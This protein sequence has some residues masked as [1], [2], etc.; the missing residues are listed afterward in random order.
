MAMTLSRSRSDWQYLY[1]KILPIA[2]RVY[3]TAV[4]HPMAGPPRATV[5][6]LRQT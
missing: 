3:A 2:P 6:D 4:S 5:P 1:T